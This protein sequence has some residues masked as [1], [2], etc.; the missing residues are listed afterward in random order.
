MMKNS[1][2]RRMFTAGL[3]ATA[4]MLPNGAAALN[5]ASAER[6]IDRLVGDINAVIASGKSENAMYREFEQRRGKDNDVTSNR[7]QCRSE[8]PCFLPLFFV[9]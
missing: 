4:L 8:F 1:L 3:G 2:N 5:S 9:K 6:L 7:R